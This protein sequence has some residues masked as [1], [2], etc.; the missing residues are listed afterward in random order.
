MGI[1]HLKD[2]KVDEVFKNIIKEN[3]QLKLLQ[4]LEEIYSMIFDYLKLKYNIDQLKIEI[5]KATKIEILYSSEEIIEDKFLNELIYNQNKNTDICFFIHSKNENEKN[6]VTNNIENIKLSLDIF[7][8]SLYNK[9]LEKSII[10]LTLVD[11]ITGAYNRIFLDTY[12]ENILSISNREQKKVA[13]LKVGIDKF[14]AVVEEFDYAI[15]DKVLKELFSTIKDSVRVS[16]IIVRIA[17]DEF[18]VILM[19]V[20]NEDNAIIVSNKLINNF[21]KKEVIVNVISKQTIMKTIC[22]GFSIFPDDGSTI[23][24]VIKKSDIALCEAKNIGRSQ[25]FKYSEEETSTIDFF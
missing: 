19:N 7:S 1:K 4:S 25:I 18:L 22:V 15:G 3:Q 24:D 17:E 12:I 2:K 8:L 21:L 5:R 13:F 23:E 10:D 14:K 9:F 16:D 20:I 11:P 6:N